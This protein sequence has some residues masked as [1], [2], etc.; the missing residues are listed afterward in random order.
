MAQ[1]RE[2]EYEMRIF[3]TVWIIVCLLSLLLAPAK[4]LTLKKHLRLAKGKFEVPAEIK[5]QIKVEGLQPYLDSKRE[6]MRM[7]AVRRLGEIEGLKAVGLLRAIFTKEPSTRGL[8]DIPLV[9]LEIIRTLKRIGTDQ[10]K[11]ELLDILK[12]YWQKGPNVKDKRGFRLDRDFTNV[13]PLLFDALYKWSGEE[14]VFKTVETIALSEDVKKFYAGS[15]S[16]GQKAWEVHLKGK[17][18][19]EGIVEGE[20]TAIYLLEFTQQLRKQSSYG[21]L[22]N[23]QEMA[24]YVVLQKHNKAVLSSLAQKLDKELREN[25]QALEPDRERN[26]KLEYMVLCINGALQEKAKRD[27]ATQA[28]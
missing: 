18:I 24:A 9:K 6:F 19:R 28:Q 5:K 3:T 12:D 13:M 27:K 17:I 16:I 22:E 8:H 7:A 4:A 2:G 23:I 25:K 14:D 10:A 20:Q 15:Y 21:K 11:S 26:D 1:I